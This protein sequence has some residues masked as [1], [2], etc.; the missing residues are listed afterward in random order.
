MTDVVVVS[1]FVNRLQ[2]RADE[3]Y[4]QY[5]RDMTRDVDI[6]RDENI[7]Y[8]FS[9]PEEEM[10]PPGFSTYVQVE[11]FGDKIPG[12]Y[13]STFF[14]GMTTSAMKLLQIVK[15]SFFFLGQKDGLQGAI[16]RK[17]MIDLNINTEVVVTPVVRD[18]SGLAYAARTRFLTAAQKDAAAV[19]YRSLLAAETA[20]VAG[21]SQSR[22]IVKVITDVIGSEPSARLEYAVVVD[23]ATL[24]PLRKIKESALIGVGAMIG[25]SLLND[26]VLIETPARAAGGR[27]RDLM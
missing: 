26:S 6:L 10:Y 13:R 2:F 7:D 22:K 12:L 3:E 16:L 27:E 11:G 18:A 23:P 15:P 4:Q 17:M 9:P 8:I 20:I 5:P 25:S 21:E 14:K 19:I 24:E 1:I